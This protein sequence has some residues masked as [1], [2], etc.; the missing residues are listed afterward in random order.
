MELVVGMGEYII[1]NREDDV[2]RTYALASCVAVTAYSPLRKIAGM[3]H[4]VLPS[5]L[6]SRDHKERP[7][8]FAETGVPLL[9]N[10]ICVQYGCRKEELNIRMYGGAESI[11]DQDIFNIGQ[12]NIDAIKHTL[13]TMGLI[14][15][16]ADLRGSSSRTLAM[17]VRTGTVEVYRQA[18]S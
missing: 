15:H 16:K 6:G 1:S 7:G 10:T 2:L 3:I 11:R 13:L 8:Y 9:I 12:K 5:P 14:I 17:D 4:V 18:I